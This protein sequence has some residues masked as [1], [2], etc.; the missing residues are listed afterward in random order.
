[1]RLAFDIHNEIGRLWDERIFRNELAN[2]C[3]QA[4][5]ENAEIEVPVI[6]TH[7]GF[8]KRYFVDLVINDS[9]IYELKAVSKLSP[10]HDK[11]ALHYL[12]LF[13]LQHGKLINFRPPSVE[14]RF[15]STTLLP[16]DRYNI[17]VEDKHWLELNADSIWLKTLL[18]ELLRDWGA[19][20]ETTLFYEAIY[21][22]RGGEARVIH[23]IEIVLNGA[24]LGNQKVHLLNPGTAFKITALTKGIEGYQQNLNRFMRLTNLNALQWINFNHH[25]VSFKTILNHKK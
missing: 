11:Q 9:V 8:I 21:H 17:V 22:F 20:L 1:M 3:R 12:F 19:Y 15:V 18:I 10:E 6:V 4:G 7:Q 16:Q 5:F 25:V 2:R 24:K 14:K 23:D 13:G